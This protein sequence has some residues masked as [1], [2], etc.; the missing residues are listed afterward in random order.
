MQ[1]EKPL[2][3]NKKG[4]RKKKTGAIDAE[5][6]ARAAQKSA[7]FV[8]MVNELAEPLCAAEGLELVHVEYQRESV[9][10]TLRLYID[11]PGGVTL[12]DCGDIS[13]QLSDMLD[14]A[15]NM[16]ESYR[17]EV[18][19]PGVNR[20]VS[21]LTDFDRFKG[22]RIKIRTRVSEGGKKKYTGV[23][24]GTSGEHV[25]LMA[26]EKKISINIKEIERARLVNYNGEG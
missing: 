23:L 1:R 20:P 6:R 12:D 4:K 18:S 2:K 14:V 16:D 22:K 10:R 7:T 21:K 25:E 5:Y 19:S 24:C 17:L 8:S 26:G 3:K 9:G 11:R 13:R 15:L